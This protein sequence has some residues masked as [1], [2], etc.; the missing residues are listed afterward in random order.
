MSRNEPL[1]LIEHLSPGI[2]KDDSSRRNTKA[3]VFIG[4]QTGAI[5]PRL[6]I[7]IWFDFFQGLSF[8]S[9]E[10]SAYREDY[11]PWF[12]EVGWRYLSDIDNQRLV[13]FIVHTCGSA[14]RQFVD[15]PKEYV[16]LL[17][18]KSEDEQVLLHKVLGDQ[19]LKSMD[20]L[21]LGGEVASSMTMQDVIAQVQNTLD[22]DDVDRYD[23]I[24]E[25]EKILFSSQVVGDNSDL[26]TE[27][28]FQVQALFDFI[29]LFTKKIPV[30][31]ITESYF[32]LLRQA[33]R[34]QMDEETKIIL[35]AKIVREMIPE[36]SKSISQNEEMSEL[37]DTT[38]STEKNL[39]GA[40]YEER[41]TLRTVFQSAQS[42][43]GTDL[44]TIDIPV[45]LSYL[46]TQ[47]T[48]Q[49]DER[50]RDLVRF[51][52]STGKFEWNTDMLSE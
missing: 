14:I 51:N 17:L 22:S 2:F 52:E 29:S 34:S 41:D 12:V 8:S 5:D 50:I 32:D 13:P 35:G 27:E 49:G 7:A 36:Q 42:T 20:D 38:L 48:E 46:D 30:E 6:L 24:A 26:R 16:F 31:R 18:S 39:Q 19:M 33:T 25:F 23:R 28:V 11:W 3:E 9:G 10:V 45:L 40:V 37:V 47:A 4:L 15:V 44:S 1:Q 43:F 21:G